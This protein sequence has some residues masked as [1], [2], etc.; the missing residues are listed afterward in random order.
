MR[1]QVFSISRNRIHRLPSYFSQF[2]NLDTFKADQNP[3]E[4]PP[5]DVMEPPYGE[6][7]GAMREWI[8]S[9]QNWIEEN[10]HTSERKPSDDQLPAEVSIEVEPGTSTYAL[11]CPFQ[12]L[13]SSYRTVNR[14][15]TFDITREYQFAI[16]ESMEPSSSHQRT[17]SLDSEVSL[18]SDILPQP[19]PSTLR[20]PRSPKSPRPPRLHLDAISTSR[21]ASTSTS[22]NR[23]PESYLPTPDESVSSSEGDG[24]RSTTRA[25][26]LGRNAPYSEGPRSPSRSGLLGQQS[27]PDMRP[28]KHNLGNLK[29]PPHSSS[30]DNYG[31]PSPPHRQ[32]SDSSN[33]SLSRLLIGRVFGQSHVVSSPVSLQ[34]AAPSMDGERNSY[35]RRLSTLNPSVLSK[36]IPPALLKLVDAIRGIL[37]GVCQIYQA[38]HHYTVY[39]IDERLSAVLL[40]VLDPAHAYMNQLIHALDRFDTMSRKATPSPAVCRTVVEACRD[41]VT[42]FGKAVGMLALQLKVIATNDDARYTRQMLLVLYGAMA[43]ISNAWQ[44]MAGHLDAVKPLLREHRPPPIRAAVTPGMDSPGYQLGSARTAPSPLPTPTHRPMTRSIPSTEA[45]GAK[46]HVNRRHAGSFSSKD[47]EIG[48]M[49][50]SYIEPPYG[51]FIPD[52]LPHPTMPRFPR[53]PSAPVINGG[54]VSN[55]GTIRPMNSAPRWDSH[56]RQSSVGSLFAS[57]A[58]S[59]AFGLRPPALDILSATTTVVDKQAIDAVRA[60]VEAAPAVWETTDELLRNDPV[61][62]EELHEKLSR[63][64]EI[65]QSLRSNIHLLGTGEASSVDRRALR[66]DAHSFANVSFIP[67]NKSTG[68]C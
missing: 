20:T 35:F 36:S 7:A 66:D 18:Y 45:A 23:S 9:V 48:K 63:A 58:S 31:L 30:V 51:T 64:K 57:A 37:F 33:G 60:A 10:A 13:T 11:P 17:F 59:P 68:S 12:S 52:S 67:S 6:S 19:G 46:T 27:L 21:G 62:E 24:T 29:D 49:L 28:T 16:D 56:S 14:D 53:R 50:P 65:T 8:K 3:L 43:E 32:E 55:D 40:K 41:N 26:P 34:Q 15:D 2:R 5:K 1:N 42:V 44:S 39:A 25:Q 61:L 54:Y 4:W 47:V 38:L 22:P